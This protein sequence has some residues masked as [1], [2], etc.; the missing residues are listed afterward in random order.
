MY[1]QARSKSRLGERGSRHRLGKGIR[2]GW[3]GGGASRGCALT[4]KNKRLYYVSTANAQCLP[5]NV[6]TTAFACL[7]VCLLS[8][9]YPEPRTLEQN[10]HF[11][12][13]PPSGY[14]RPD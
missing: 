5:E 13:Q 3:D 6:P 4:M 1:L 2:G 11:A 14:C 8:S 10:A 9:S 7:C 12:Q